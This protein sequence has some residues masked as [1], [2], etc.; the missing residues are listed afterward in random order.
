MMGLMKVWKGSVVAVERRMSKA[1]AR[2]E[3]GEKSRIERAIMMLRN[4][5]IS[6]AGKALESMGLGDFD[7]PQVWN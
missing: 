6:R 4:G 3:R 2:K 7:D 1:K 5:A